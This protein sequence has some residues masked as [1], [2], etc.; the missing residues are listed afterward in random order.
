[1]KEFLE[2]ATVIVLVVVLFAFTLLIGFGVIRTYVRVN[3]AL[4]RAV[5][6][7]DFMQNII[8]HEMQEVTQ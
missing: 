6:Y 5:E 3:K 8:T 4:D 7:M 2:R 1:M